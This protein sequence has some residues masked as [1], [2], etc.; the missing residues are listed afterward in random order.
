MMS[1]FAMIW[2]IWFVLL[3]SGMGRLA[4]LA[5][6]VVLGKEQAKERVQPAADSLVDSRD[7]G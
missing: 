1:C 3:V 2:P 6:T 5:Q 7:A 4:M